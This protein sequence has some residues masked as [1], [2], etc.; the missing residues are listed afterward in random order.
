MRLLLS[1]GADP[2]F[3]LPQ[4]YPPF[5]HNGIDYDHQS[6]RALDATAEC[7]TPTIFEMLLDRGAKLENALP[8]HAALGSTRRPA[9]ERIPMME[10]LVSKRHCDVNALDA[11]VPDHH[12]LGTPLHYAVRYGKF[13]EA[14]WL[15]L[16][17][18]EPGKRNQKGLRA[19][20]FA[21][22]SGRKDT[23]LLLEKLQQA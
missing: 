16:A 19:S 21:N 15:L 17:G 14:L 6:S 22:V 4:G 9:G 2:N 3:G 20:D 18:A 10:Y 23:E 11:K 5:A 13:E 12:Q 8:L 7:S 1:H